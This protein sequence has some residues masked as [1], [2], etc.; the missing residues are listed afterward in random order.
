[1]LADAKNNLAEYERQ[2]AAAAGDQAKHAQLI[3]V[4]DKLVARV[5]NLER[6]I[7]SFR[8]ASE[9]DFVSIGLTIQ[10]VVKISIDKQPL[11]DKRK[12]FDTLMQEAQD[13][14]NPVEA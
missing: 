2:I 5:E 8:A 4:V 10:D 3:S 7:Q 6:Q 9:S 14:Q 12:S 11:I 1:M 13:Q